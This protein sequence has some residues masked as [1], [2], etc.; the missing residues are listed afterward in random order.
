ME[1]ELSFQDTVE[2]STVPQAVVRSTRV[3]EKPQTYQNSPYNH[4]ARSMIRTAISNFYAH[5]VDRRPEGLPDMVHSRTLRKEC[6]AMMTP[7]HVSNL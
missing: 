3:T 7:H 4:L 2:L 5:A 6:I 1:S